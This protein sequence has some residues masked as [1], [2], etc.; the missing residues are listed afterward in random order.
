MVVNT[1]ACDVVMNE[2]HSTFLDEGD[3]VCVFSAHS[4]AR[5][6][7]EYFINGNKSNNVIADLLY[8][9]T[10][11]NY[12]PYVSHTNFPSLRWFSFVNPLANICSV[13]YYALDANGI[14]KRCSTAGLQFVRF[15]VTGYKKIRYNN[16]YKYARFGGILYF[17]VVASAHASQTKS[18]GVRETQAV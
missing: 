9:C 17:H 13:N 16:I 14:H 15:Y 18:G 4:V 5:W 1:R 8:T 11:V 7:E 6:P 3:V 12:P 2:T 10:R